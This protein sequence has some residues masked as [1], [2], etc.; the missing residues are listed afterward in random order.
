MVLSNNENKLTINDDIIELLTWLNDAGVEFEVPQ[1]GLEEAERST[2]VSHSK[3]T[4]K[5][6]DHRLFDEEEK[7]RCM[8]HLIPQ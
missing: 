6:H 4:S 7:Q 1:R 5:N 8:S 3:I 2:K